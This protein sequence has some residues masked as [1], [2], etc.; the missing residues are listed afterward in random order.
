MLRINLN[1]PEIKIRY[2]SLYECSNIR[3]K[4]FLNIS[5]KREKV[6]EIHRTGMKLKKL[7]EA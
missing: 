4:P 2:A 7:M 1:E 3:L 6:F 5:A